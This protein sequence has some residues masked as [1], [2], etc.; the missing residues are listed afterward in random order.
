MV[1]VGGATLMLI[2]CA[3]NQDTS[4]EESGVRIETQTSVGARTGLQNGELLPLEERA[5]RAGVSLA[6]AEA[7]EK[8]GVHIANNGSVYAEECGAARRVSR[9]AG[10][11][12]YC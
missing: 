10:K 3:Q 9:P 11:A 7:W 1:L 2:G 4:G 6:L 8:S 12:I 5:K